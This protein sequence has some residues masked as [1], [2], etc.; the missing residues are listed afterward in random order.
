MTDGSD[1]YPTDTFVTVKPEPVVAG[2]T[3]E[4]VLL[5]QETSDDPEPEL[6]S[7]DAEVED[8]PEGEEGSEELEESTLDEEQSQVMLLSPDASFVYVQNKWK[9]YNFRAISAQSD[10]I[11]LSWDFGDGVTSAQRELDHVFKSHG[12]FDVTLRITDAEGNV[13]TDTEE[14]MISFFHM[15]NPLI[16]I[17]IGVLGLFILIFL[18]LIFKKGKPRPGVA[19]KTMRP[20]P[21]KK[22][23]VS[24]PP[25]R[26]PVMS[27]EVKASSTPPGPPKTAGATAA[28]VLQRA[29]VPVKSAV[30]TGKS[31]LSS[32]KPVTEES[33]K[34][35]V[36]E[37]PAKKAVSRKP[38]K[39]RSASGGK[40]SVKKKVPAKKKATK[41]KP[42]AKKKTSTKKKSAAKKPVKKRTAKKK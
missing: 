1:Y 3:D 6:I 28:A 18:I 36:K 16:K 13:T 20:A 27:T 23:M 25:G 5:A 15:G 8:L 10:G 17:I 35:T 24:T 30:D 26:A 32:A 40:A 31:V 9:D 33:S 41:K 42:A 22:V 34:P 12:S 7:E 38:A 19:A 37:T 2:E 39:G 14:V 4:P 21:A 11:S 29:V